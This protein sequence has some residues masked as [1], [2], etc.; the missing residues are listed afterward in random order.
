[1]SIFSSFFKKKS[2]AIKVEALILWSSAV[3][4]VWVA[5]VS[6]CVN[7]LLHRRMQLKSYDSVCVRARTYKCMCDTSPSVCV[8]LMQKSLVYDL[9]FIGTTDSSVSVSVASFRF[10]VCCRKCKDVSRSRRKTLKNIVWLRKKKFDKLWAKTC[11]CRG[12]FFLFLQ[13]VCLHVVCVCVCARTK[14]LL[15][16]RTVGS[17]ISKT[18]I[19]KSFK[20]CQRLKH[21]LSVSLVLS[22]CTSLSRSLPRSLSISVVWFLFS[23]YWLIPVFEIVQ[24]YA[25][26]QLSTGHPGRKQ[27]RPCPLS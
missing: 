5:F 22:L 27:K 23:S 8:N 12:R 20:K 17:L 3:A 14:K 10:T 25:R 15:L 1:M 16:I 26:L 6:V 4:F 2:K 18:E 24:G 19:W 11:K 13:C 9:L 7:D 21:S